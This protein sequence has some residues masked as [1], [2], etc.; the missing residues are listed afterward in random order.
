MTPQVFYSV[1][2]RLPGPGIGYTAYN[3]LRAIH[4][5]GM[6]AGI[7]AMG[8]GAC[9]VPAEKV[10]T[11]WFPS[12]RLLP[13][14]LPRYYYLKDSY[15]DWR[16][17]AYVRGGGGG[18]RLIFHGW[19]H[20]CLAS[21][22]RAKELGAVCFVE[23][24]SSHPRTQLRLIQEEADSLGLRGIGTPTYIVER[25]EEEFDLADRIMVPSQFA[26]DSMVGEGIAKEKLIVLP[27]G[28]DTERF[29]P[30]E[31]PS[32][33][34]QAGAARRDPFTI[35][36]VGELSLRKGAIYL[37][38]AWLK[39]SVPRARLVLLGAIEPQLAGIV[40]N[41]RRQ[42]WFETPG[43]QD[44]LPYYQGASVFVFPTIEEGSALVTY[45]ALA[46]GLPVI[47]TF[48]SGSVVRDGVEGFIVPI[49]DAEAI[50]ECIDRLADEG[51]H[52][53]MSRAAR[54]RACEYTWDRY[55]DNLVSVYLSVLGG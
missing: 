6:V 14:S 31:R 37:L 4:R 27:F 1:G 13:L 42:R 39:V 52:R 23:R 46:C 15:F 48:N 7:S 12:R 47:T 38:K 50:V 53:E 30:A 26:Y 41:F 11:I 21:M 28:A 55:G 5:R 33:G 24:A 2:A 19:A 35:L 9:E 49:R 32:V 43:F 36:F 40:E 10:R 51:R 20:Q 25:M 29:R 17:S 45:E 44:P 16:V 8:Y 54:E 34:S 18:G 22:R 3:A